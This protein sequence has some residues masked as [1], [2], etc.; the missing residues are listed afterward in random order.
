M[1]KY[2]CFT[3]LWSLFL[4][5]C[6]RK[7]EPSALQNAQWRGEN[8][9]GVY[10]ETGLLREWPA[11]GPQLLWHFEGLGA[12]YSSAA[13]AN[14]KVYATGLDDD[15][16]AVLY[17]F[18]LTGNLLAKK[19]V[20]KEWSRSQPGPRGTVCI[21]EGKLYVYTALGELVCLDEA[22]LNEIWRK[23]LQAEFERWH[24]E[25]GVAESPLIVGDKIFMTPGGETHNMVALDKNTGELLW[26]SPGMGMRSTFC[27][28]QF[29][30]DQSVPIV[31]TNTVDYIVAFHADTGEM[32]WSHPQTNQ[33]DNHPNTPLYSDGMLFAITG[34][35]AGAMMLRLQDGGR[36]AERIWT[37]DADNL[38]GGAVKIGN[39][40]YVLGSRNRGL[41][42]IDWETGETRHK[43]D[44][45]T[46]G[47][48]IAADGMLF[49][50]TDRGECA[51]VIPS[52]DRFDIAG[53]F[54]VTLGTDQHWAHPVIHEGVLY[55]RRGDAL[56][57]YQIK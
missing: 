28:P 22:T 3:L 17:S 54:P 42:C 2:L 12:G 35:G 10:N 8:R 36:S 11:E 25:L 40:I 18:D 4:L 13:A 56:M 57:A 46:G 50:Y 45:L 19:V 26:T 1:K 27:S 37:S 34:Y 9:D 31:V 49:A 20:G 21:N 23:D 41:F 30:G 5:S 55:I 39:N 33:F 38:M 48:V 29:I 7:N 24:P 47:V 53:R 6:Q 32:L 16:N 51:L 52:T 14:G 15:N 44:E 43:S